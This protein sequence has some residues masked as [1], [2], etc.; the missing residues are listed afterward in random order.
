VSASS[1]VVSERKRTTRAKRKAISQ[2]IPKF[3]QR[4]RQCHA[5]VFPISTTSL[6][7]AES[8]YSIAPNQSQTPPL[9]NR[10]TLTQ[11]IACFPLRRP[12]R[13]DWL[14]TGPLPEILGKRWKQKDPPTRAT[15]QGVMEVTATV[16]ASSIPSPAVAE[17]LSEELSA[18]LSKPV[19]VRLAV[20]QVVETGD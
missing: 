2:L 9:G 20:L 11:S 14:T 16:H 7:P 8:Q 3:S 6:L 18:R 10:A 17:R 15:Q 1:N 12:N 19:R 5:L 13:Y 4:S